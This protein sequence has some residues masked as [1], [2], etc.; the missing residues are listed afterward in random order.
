MANAEHSHRRA[1]EFLSSA[2]I[3]FVRESVALAQSNLH[4]GTRTFREHLMRRLAT[5]GWSGQVRVDSRSKIT[6]SSMRGTLAMC[7]QTGNMSRMY[8][9]LLKLETLYRKGLITCAL[10]VLPCRDLAGQIGSN[11]A[12]FERLVEE[13]SIFEVTVTVPVLVIGMR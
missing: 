10:Y 7:V 8:A 6:I 9:D 11:I 13:L 5:K 3:D 12:A 1:E 2:D 4:R